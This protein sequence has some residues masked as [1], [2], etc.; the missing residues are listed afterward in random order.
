[1][2]RFVQDQERHVLMTADA[3]GGVLHYALDL[4]SGLSGHGVRTTLAMLG[5]SP[6]E[7]Q[8]RAAR[9]VPGLQLLETG[10]PL[11][12]LAAD[13][14]SARR[15]ALELAELAHRH[16][17]DLVHLNTPSLACAG[18]AVPVVS[19]LHSCVA[20]WWARAGCGPMPDDFRWRTEL[21]AQGIARTDALVCPSAALAGEIERIYGRRPLVVHNGRA[22]AATAASLAPAPFAVTAGRLWDEG[23]NVAT[24]DAASRRIDWPVYAAGPTEGPNGTRIELLGLRGLGAIGS[25]ELR[26]LLARR[27][28]F[29]ASA[30]YE[31]F[32]LAVLEAAQAGCALL[33]SDIPTFRE[34]WEDAAIFVPPHDADGFAEG[35]SRL[36]TDPVRRRALGDAAKQR[37]ARYTVNAMASRMLDIY[38]ATA[39]DAR[40][41]EEAL[42]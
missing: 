23:K 21:M 40:R 35:L 16:R 11:D 42:A 10:L 28:V 20:S 27:P 13:A 30:L 7:A 4:A 3:V 17:V 41:S 15:A 14:G 5:P 26:S 29:V 39:A 22:A 18:Y 33:L 19:V 32:G 1:M 31:P 25:S 12:W 38:G 34:L 8:R 24:L 36:L 2:T 9:S 37:A 6:D